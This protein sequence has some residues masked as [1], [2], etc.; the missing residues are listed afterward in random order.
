MLHSA[1][2]RKDRLQLNCLKCRYINRMLKSSKTFICCYL[3]ITLCVSRWSSWWRPFIL[4]VSSAINSWTCLRDSINCAVLTWCALAWTVNSPVS[5]GLWVSPWLCYLVT[6]KTTHF[7]VFAE[8]GYKAGFTCWC[9]LRVPG[10]I[11]LLIYIHK[12]L[13]FI[14]AHPLLISFSIQYLESFA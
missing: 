3:N 9:H 6:V 5:R 11:A 14:E 8:T 13:Q 4:S 10:W 7:F 2:F 1:L 12:E